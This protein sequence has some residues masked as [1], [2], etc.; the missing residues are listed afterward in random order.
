MYRDKIKVLD[1]TI[2]DGGLINNHDFDHRFVRAVYKAISEAGVD[3]MEMGYKNTKRLFSPKEYG[4]WKFCDDDEIKRIIDGI[5][6]DTKI[7]VMVDVDRVDIEDVKP[8]KESPVDMIRTAS[9][10][11][12]ID[13]AIYMVN[14]FAEKGYETT[15]NI[16][17]ISRDMGPELDEALRQIEEESKVNVVYIV[18]SFGALYQEP[19]EYLVKK[20]RV[21]LKTREV[22]FHG[23][24]HQQLAFGNTIE[25]IIHDANYLD[26]TIYGIGRAAGNCPLELLIGFLKNPKFDIR[27]IL[28]LISKEFIPL[29]NKIEWGY[30][31]PYAISG[32]MNEHP[33]AAMALRKSEKKENY[34]EFY[35][36]LNSGLD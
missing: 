33:K 11:K 27:P 35:E 3:Y 34:K 29:R 14:H 1:C 30:I 26:G 7:S 21:I 4:A 23:H 25:A 12:D 9:Y 24:N 20:A 15:I 5:E 18:D 6:S 28:D 19:V 32:M 36:S 8:A 13:K 22:G 17:A 16:M 2:R 31:I 10:V